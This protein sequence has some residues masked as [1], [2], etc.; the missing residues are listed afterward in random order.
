MGPTSPSTLSFR[1]YLALASLV[2]PQQI[3]PLRTPLA[4]FTPW[5]LKSL[6][7]KSLP[8][9]EPIL[10]PPL[11]TLCTT[12]ITRPQELRISRFCQW[13]HLYLRRLQRQTLRCRHWRSLKHRETCSTLLRRMRIHD[14]NRQRYDGFT[15]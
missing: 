1:I 4:S 5:W 9:M 3:G 6:A 10:L 7:T 11:R 14:S 13:F 12:S 8:F 15:A 2:A